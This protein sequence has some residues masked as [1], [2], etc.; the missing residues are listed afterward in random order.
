MGASGYRRG[1]PLPGAGGAIAPAPIAP[2]TSITVAA[3][4]FAV[5]P[6]AAAA[7]F[8]VAFARLGQGVLQAQFLQGPAAAEFDAIVLVDVDDQTFISSPTLQTSDTRLTKPSDSSLMWHSPSLPGR[9]S[10]NAPKSLML[11]TRPS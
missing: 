5:A 1:R 2:I 9:I 10:T 6:F 4:T 11:V 3:T 8:L 7:A